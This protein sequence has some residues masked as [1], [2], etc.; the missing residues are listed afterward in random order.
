MLDIRRVTVVCLP[1]RVPVLMLP[2]RARQGRRTIIKI[3][4]WLKC[5]N[6]GYNQRADMDGD[7]VARPDTR[8]FTVACKTTMT[9]TFF[10]RDGTP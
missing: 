9:L 3:A 5:N 2:E 6:S 7:C 4:A 8:I 1:H 10:D